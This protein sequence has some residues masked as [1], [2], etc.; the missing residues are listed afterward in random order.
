MWI[1]VDNLTLRPL[2][3]R[4]CALEA[5]WT[6]ESV[7]TIWRKEKNVFPLSGFEPL[8]KIIKYLP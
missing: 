4:E 6:V 1:L 2:Y 8:L 5:G 7:R 3:P